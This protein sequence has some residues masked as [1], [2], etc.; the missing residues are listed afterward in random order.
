FSVAIDGGLATANASAWYNRVAG[1]S[2]T[3]SGFNLIIYA[4]AG[5][6]ASYLTQLINGTWLD[7]SSGGVITGGD[8]ARWEQ[9]STSLLLPA[10]TDFLS[11]RIMAVEN[12]FNDGTMP[13]FDGH[14]A[15]ATYLDI[16]VIPEPATL[17]LLLVGGLAM[18]RRRQ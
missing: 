16:D 13:E 10:G 15:D 17:G 9:G 14:Y 5:S 2:Q 8:A 3:D 1:D 4:F 11:L 6:P 12:I 18:L 7:S